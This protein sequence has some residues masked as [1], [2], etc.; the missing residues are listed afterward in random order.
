MTSH[1]IATKPTHTAHV[2]FD[3][4]FKEGQAAIGVIIRYSTSNILGGLSGRIVGN[5]AS[6]EIVEA[7]AFIHAIRLASIYGLQR[8]NFF[9]DCAV[10]VQKDVTNIADFS[11]SGNFVDLISYLLPIFYF[12]VLSVK[13][14]HNVPTH[15]LASHGMR[16]PQFTEWTEAMSA[17]VLAAIAADS[18]LLI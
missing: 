7:Y 3:G 18:F 4:A 16:C 8:I 13:C 11:A 9:S 12:F 6:T 5:L 17:D 2:H 14:S 10:L 1:P 15:L